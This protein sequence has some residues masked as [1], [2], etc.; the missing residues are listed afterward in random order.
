MSGNLYTIGYA[1]F[2]SFEEFLEPLKFFKINSIIDVRSKPFSSRYPDYNQDV[3]RKKLK[4]AGILYVPMPD[5]GVHPSNEN[6]FRNGT[7][8]WELIAQS[9]AFR[10]SIGR[11]KKGMEMYRCCLL[12]AEK[13]PQNCHRAILIGRY[14]RR[15]VPMLHIEAQGGL[16]D[17]VVVELRLLEMYGMDRQEN[18][19]ESRED[20]IAEV[21]KRQS[22]KLIKKWIRKNEVGYD[23]A[24]N[25]PGM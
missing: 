6:F 20:A 7:P 5:L 4:D 15:S 25:M 1:A 8:D 3:L 23:Q 9:K 17:T 22:K 24:V 16:T 11:V 2:D 18:L 14:L 13:E 19:F 12:C 21:Y 10:G